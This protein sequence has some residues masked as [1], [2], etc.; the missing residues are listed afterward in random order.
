MAKMSS[1]GCIKNFKMPDR[2]KNVDFNSE[3]NTRF[4]KGS[5]R[6][7]AFEVVMQCVKNGMKLA[8]IRKKMTEVRKENGYG[9]NLDMNYANFV[10]ASHPE[11]FKVYTDGSIDLVDE[12]VIKTKSTQEEKNKKI[13]RMKK[14]AREIKKLRDRSTEKKGREDVNNSSM[15]KKSAVN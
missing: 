14:A 6:Q 4:P 11:Y 5:A 9:F 1:R 12:P 2:L 15:G 7:F 13:R 10:V 3:T 8:D